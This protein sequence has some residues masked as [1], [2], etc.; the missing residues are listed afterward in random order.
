MPPSRAAPALQALP[1]DKGPLS[2]SLQRIA[3]GRVLHPKERLDRGVFADVRGV[4]DEKRELSV[5]LDVEGFRFEREDKYR[6]PRFEPSTWLMDGLSSDTP[7]R[8]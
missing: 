1:D 8:V 2:Q 7:V 4:S 3:G 5:V 6:T